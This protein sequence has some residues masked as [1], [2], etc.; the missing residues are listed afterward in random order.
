MM[1]LL[2]YPAARQQGGASDMTSPGAAASAAEPHQP[3]RCQW[4]NDQESHFHHA[5]RFQTSPLTQRSCTDAWRSSCTDA[6]Q[7]RCGCVALDRTRI[8]GACRARMR[9][10]VD[11]DAWLLIDAR[12]Q[13]LL[14][15]HGCISVIGTPDALT[16]RL[17]Q[18]S[19]SMPQFDNAFI[20]RMRG[21]NDRTRMRGTA[22]VHGCVALS[23]CTDA[24]QRS[25]G[26]VAWRDQGTGCISLAI[27]ARMRGGDRADAW[28]NDR[29][30]MRGASM[31]MRG[32][33]IVPGCCGARRCWMRSGNRCGCVAWRDRYG[34]VAARSVTDACLLV[35]TGCVAASMRAVA[36]VDTH[37]CVARSRTPDAVAWLSNAR[38]RGACCTDAIACSSMPGSAPALSQPG[39]PPA[40]RRRST[41]ATALSCCGCDGG[42]RTQ[43]HACCQWTDT[44]FNQYLVPLCSNRY[45]C[46]LCCRST[47]MRS[48][49]IH[50]MH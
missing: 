37:G 47:R 26:C 31:R 27:D 2:T 50:R 34:Y 28:P 33:A 7:R 9:G 44:C 25:C 19:A 8:R 30:R 43:I 49:S 48:A 14:S 16:R 10:G 45:G 5:R 1:T 24:W 42:C 11:A 6:W 35:D 39:D 36:A 32:T 21:Y 13:Q 23:Q 29:A 41:D 38:M 4:L 18:Q 46:V 15:I 20:V 12:M 17:G 3:S 22:I 40:R